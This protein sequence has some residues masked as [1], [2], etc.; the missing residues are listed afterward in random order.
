M[1]FRGRCNLLRSLFWAGAIST[2]LL[3]ATATAAELTVRVSNFQSEQGVLNI[4]VYDN[5][6]DWL[7]NNFVN[8]VA[9]RIS[10]EAREGVV[11]AT[12]ELVPGAYAVSVHHD[13]NDNGKMDTNFIGIPKEPIGLS[14]GA[15]AKFG[16]PKYKDAV[17]TMSEDGAKISI[18]LLD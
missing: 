6:E 1:K 16:P 11:T 18:Q 4:T 10:E 2:L 14:N 17:F 8:T 13:D 9:L 12:F 5:A 7:G 3:S 15:L